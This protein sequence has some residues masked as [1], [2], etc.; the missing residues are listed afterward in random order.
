[1]F[2]NTLI[3]AQ[4][5][6]QTGKCTYYSDR[7][8]GRKT[9][10]GEKY[11]KNLYTAAHRKLPFNTYVK[12][13]NIKNNKS[14]IVKINDRGPFSKHL[15][16]D[17][18]KIAAQELDIIGKGVAPVIINVVE[19]PSKEDSLKYLNVISSSQLDIANP[20]V[21]VKPD[22]SSAISNKVVNTNYEINKYYDDNL[23]EIIP[24]G[25][26]IQVGYFKS[27][28]NCS[29]SMKNFAAKYKIT[30][31][32]KVESKKGNKY[33]KLIVGIFSTR[34]EVKEFQKKVITE[35]PSCLIISY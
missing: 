20:K 12:V 13:T 9:S 25:Y 2:F 35:V 33:Y 23:K 34:N 24:K 7:F 29:I 5:F 6:Q 28:K 11:D 22:S 3:F 26:G 8:H 14:V 21:I 18:S 15:I 4:S 1:M 27:F 19:N 32:F 31:L 30:S 17:V 16:I 10:S